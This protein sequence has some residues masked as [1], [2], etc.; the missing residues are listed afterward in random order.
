[1][2]GTLV[3][4]RF[5]F[6]IIIPLFLFSFFLKIK[7]KPTSHTSLRLTSHFFKR[8]SLEA[9]FSLF[10]SLLASSKQFYNVLS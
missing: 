8:E 4:R 3:I 5:K 7:S 2:F 10:S 1:M 6:M 9:L